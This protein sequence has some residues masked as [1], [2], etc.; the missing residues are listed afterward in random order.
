VLPAV[1]GVA[2]GALVNQAGLV[3][4]IVGAGLAL[5]GLAAAAALTM[6]VLRRHAGR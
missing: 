6:P 4:A 3:P 1:S 2:A 5:A